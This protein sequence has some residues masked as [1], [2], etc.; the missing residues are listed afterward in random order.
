MAALLEIGGLEISF[1][2][3]KALHGVGLTLAAGEILALIGPNGAGKTTVFNCI[4]GLY[5]PQAGSIRVDGLELVGRKPHRIAAAGIART[6]QNIELFRHMS[7][8]DNLLLGRHLFL[9]TGLLSGMAL[10]GPKSP[11]AREEM[12][13]RE[14][15]EEIIDFLDLQAARNQIVGNLPYGTQKVV[16]LGRALAMEPKVLLLDEPAAGMNLEEKHD[17]RIWIEDISTRFGIAVLLIEH[18]MQF[19][20]DLADR[21]IALNYGENI[22][23][24]TPE[25]V[26]AHPEVLRA[27]LG[28]DAT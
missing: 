18:D 4:S 2:G 23:E 16:E 3:V 11:A 1:G 28:A 17:L 8:M 13:H 20:S 7:T 21:V 27:Y 6:F 14:K 9:R 12:R 26:R 5:R 15:V 19:V 24:G 22:A 25:A 10:F